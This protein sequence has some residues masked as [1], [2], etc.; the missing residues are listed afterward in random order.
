[1]NYLI[2]FHISSDRFDTSIGGLIFS[3]QFIQIA[4]YLNTK[5]VYG[6]GENSHRT[7]RHDLKYKTWPIFARDNGVQNVKKSLDQFMIL[8]QFI[9]E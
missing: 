6:L 8:K 3:D 7:L 5:N 2:F 1:L 4:S 9:I